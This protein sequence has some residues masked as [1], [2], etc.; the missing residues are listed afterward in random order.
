MPPATK[1][2]GTV[3]YSFLFTS[4]SASPF[5][6]LFACS[7]PIPPYGLPHLLPLLLLPHSLRSLR[8]GGGSALVERARCVRIARSGFQLTSID[9]TIGAWELGSR[10]SFPPECSNLK[11]PNRCGRAV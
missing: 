1:A 4:M 3:A 9:G 8:G 2:F 7:A 5:P 11:G 10:R 6:P